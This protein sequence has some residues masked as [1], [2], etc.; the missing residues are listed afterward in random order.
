MCCIY[1]RAA[2]VISSWWRTQKGGSGMQICA[3]CPW[4]SCG[5]GLAE[6]EKRM[7]NHGWWCGGI[8][9]KQGTELSAG[10][11]TKPFATWRCTHEVRAQRLPC[12]VE[13]ESRVPGSL[14]DKLAT[15]TDFLR[16]TV[17]ISGACGGRA[18]ISCGRYMLPAPLPEIRKKGKRK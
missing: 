15:N 14:P 4:P 1:T 16:S 7:S 10:G 11:T 9:E 17:D 2:E 18:G 8:D 6:R 5:E 3:C 13:Q 12:L